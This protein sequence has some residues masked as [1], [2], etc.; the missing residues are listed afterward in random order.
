MQGT[1][2]LN[3]I[4]LLSF[5]RKVRSEREYFDEIR[6][7]YTPKR[8]QPEI[9]GILRGKCRNQGAQQKR[10]QRE[11]RAAEFMTGTPVPGRDPP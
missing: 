2:N 6:E 7:Q 8:K 4:I 11:Q 3:V 9:S 5:W 1:K 10:E